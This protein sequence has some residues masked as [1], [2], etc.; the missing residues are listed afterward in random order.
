[1]RCQSR[2][3][4]YE[5]RFVAQ[6]IGSELRRIDEVKASHGLQKPH[7]DAF[8]LQQLHTNEVTTHHFLKSKSDGARTPLVQAAH[9]QNHPWSQIIKLLGIRRYRSTLVDSQCHSSPSATPALIPFEMLS[10]LAIV[11]RKYRECFVSGHRNG[12]DRVR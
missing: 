9:C 6:R 12:H 10:V 8:Q 4:E 5:K 11:I 1:M 7:P 3:N 2:R